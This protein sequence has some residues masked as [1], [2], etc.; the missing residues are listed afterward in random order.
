MSDLTPAFVRIR[1]Q[2]AQSEDWSFLLAFCRVASGARAHDDRNNNP[3]VKYGFYQLNQVV[4]VFLL[5]QHTVEICSFSR[6]F[7]TFAAKYLKD[8]REIAAVH[9]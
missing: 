3:A 5:Q 9:L 1:T 8:K 2:K 4:K 7:E 6:C